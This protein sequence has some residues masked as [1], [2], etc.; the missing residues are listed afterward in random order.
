M[1]CAEEGCVEESP[2]VLTEWMWDMIGDKGYCPLHG[3]MRVRKLKREQY[4]N[5]TAELMTRRAN[6][7]WAKAHLDADWYRAWE[8]FQSD[9]VNFHRESGKPAHRTLRMMSPQEFREYYRRY[10]RMNVKS[11]NEH[12]EAAERAFREEK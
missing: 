4:R 11:A 10:G 5:V 1:K 6:K 7:I 2:D 3:P 12:T 8:E 9:L